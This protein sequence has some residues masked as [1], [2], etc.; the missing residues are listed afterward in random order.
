MGSELILDALVVDTPIFLAT[1]GSSPFVPN[2]TTTS[3]TT[4][5][6][7]NITFKNVSVGVID[8]TGRVLLSGG[9]HE[10]VK[11]WEQGN[12]Y[13][14]PKKD[15]EYRKGTSKGAK[16]PKKL[17]DEHGKIFSKRRP[18]YE[19]YKANRMSLQLSQIASVC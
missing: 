2:T 9:K 8:G 7:D 17:V 15:F 18:E 10:T 4:I 12:A 1:T 11:H 19:G 13:S 3:N 5:I 16:R 14:G 6:L